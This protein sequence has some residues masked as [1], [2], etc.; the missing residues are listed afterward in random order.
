[1]THAFAYIA[2]YRDVLKQLNTDEEAQLQMM[3]TMLE[4]CSSHQQVANL[5]CTSVEES[6]IFFAIAFNNLDRKADEIRSF[7]IS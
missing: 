4:V 2:K 7:E 1:M 3:N 6:S 5:N